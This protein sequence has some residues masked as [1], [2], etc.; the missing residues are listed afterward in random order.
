[1]NIS[2]PLSVP[3]LSISL[4]LSPPSYNTLDPNF[5]TLSVQATLHSSQPITVCSWHTILHPAQALQQKRF[6][7]IDKSAKSA[8]PQV[9][10][11]NK[12]PAI[13]RR[14]GTLDEKLFITLMPEVPYTVQT[15]F[16]RPLNMQ[17]QEL[18]DALTADKP[19]YGMRGLKKGEYT[20]RVS[21]AESPSGEA[22]HHI[23]WWR[24]GTKEDNL[25]RARV[26][27]ET[28]VDSSLGPSEKPTPLV[29]DVAAIPAVDFSVV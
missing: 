10:K 3:S 26:D 15:P 21:G 28:A 29:L 6:E 18:Q 13:Q 23:K 1:M 9:D 20:L 7:L 16:G 22:K 4:S 19:G 24:Y 25:E 8:V 11:K 17:T 12:R 5:P 27:G 14:L 2:T